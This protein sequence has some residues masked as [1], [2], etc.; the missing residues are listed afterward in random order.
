MSFGKAKIY[1]D[2]SHYIAIPKENFPRKKVKSGKK[3]KTVSKEKEIFERAYKDSKKLPRNERNEF[4]NEKLKETIPDTEK[5]TDFINQNNERKRNNNIKRNVRL[6]RKIRLQEWNYFCTFTYSDEILSPDDFREKLLN[7][8]KHMVNRK[9]WK[10]IGAFERSPKNER[11]HFHG[12]FYIPNMIGE[13]QETKDYNTTTCRMQT[14]YQNTHFL[15]QFGRNDFKKI[16]TDE[17]ICNSVR[18]LIKYIEKS[19]E[20]LCY[21]GKLPTYFISDILDEDILCPYG[22]K[23]KKAILYDKFMCFDEGTYMGTVSK[24]TIKEMP[25]SN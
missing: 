1:F 10:Y 8:L 17:D 2:G 19:G 5:R 11:L 3:R 9:G 21:G 18:Y 15:K 24:E 7:T 25:K 23:D 12:I 13:L 4:I 20:R 6:M 22:I 14:T 16:Y